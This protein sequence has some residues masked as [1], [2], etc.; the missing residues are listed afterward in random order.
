[1]FSHTPVLLQ[2][3]LAALDVRE[4]GRYLDATF[5]RGGHSAAI[6]ER[7]GPQ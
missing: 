4:G 3:V 2:E 1:M 6:L 7:V 5:G